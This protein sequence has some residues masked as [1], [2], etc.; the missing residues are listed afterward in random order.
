MNRLTL[1]LLLNV[2]YL[3]AFTG[4]LPWNGKNTGNP[5]IPGHFADPSLVEM[6]GKFYIYATTVSKHMEPMVWISEDM[7]NWEVKHLGI[8][9]K[10]LFWAP[11]ML[12]GEDGKYYL[13]YSSG[14]D[15]KCHLYVGETP[16]GPWEFKGKVDEGFDLQIYQ[17]PNDGK[18]YGTTSDPSSRPRLVEFNSDVDSPGYLTEVIREKN[19]EGPFFDYTEGS[20]MMYR[21]G[22][23]YYMYSG[24]KCHAENYKI[25]HARSRDIWGPYE[26]APNNPILDMD[27]GKKIFAPGHHSVIQIEDEYFIAYHRQDVYFYPTCSER[28]VC[29]DRMEFNDEG[30]IEKVAPTHEGVDFSRYFENTKADLVNVALGKNTTAGNINQSYNPRLA[31]D[32]N[33]ATFWKGSGF[34]SVDLGQDYEIE[35]ILPRFVN[36]DYYMMYKI[37]YSSDNQNW[38]TYYDQTGEARKGATPVIQKDITARYIKIE[39][40]RSGGGFELAELEVLSPKP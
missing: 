6:D 1:F 32:G 20:Y 4:E 28:Q 34:F 8:E 37:M 10:H 22:W 36:Y 31:T 35:Q 39:F 3:Q 23:Y 25:N 16:S 13:Y 2:I 12:K 15:F 40:K 19:L 21:D 7:Q 24:G 14:F 38:E 17:D 33:Y 5:I 11:S 27:P 30:W 9:G 18:V 29:I 26:D